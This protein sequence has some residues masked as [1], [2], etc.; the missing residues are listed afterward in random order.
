MTHHPVDVIMY[1]QSCYGVENDCII[2]NKKDYAENQRIP[3]LTNSIM[4]FVQRR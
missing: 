4:V 2:P 3:F 1:V